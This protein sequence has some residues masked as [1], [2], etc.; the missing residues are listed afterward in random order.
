MKGKKPISFLNVLFRHSPGGKAKESRFQPA[1]ASNSDQNTGHC[2]IVS[3]RIFPRP[4][5]CH[6]FLFSSHFSISLSACLFAFFLCES[7]S[8]SAL[9]ERYQ[10][11]IPPLTTGEFRAFIRVTVKAHMHILMQLRI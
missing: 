8:F 3:S 4:L 1:P 7:P 9:T 5:I 6:S 11:C 10:T 2:T